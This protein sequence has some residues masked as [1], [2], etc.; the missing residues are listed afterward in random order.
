MVADGSTIGVSW[1]RSLART[2]RVRL[3]RPSVRLRTSVATQR[4]LYAHFLMYDG[5]DHHR[6]HTS[7]MGII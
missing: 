3:L 7:V 5:Y 4:Q 2:Y 6:G 1:D